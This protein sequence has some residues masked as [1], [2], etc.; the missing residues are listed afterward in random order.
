M[1]KLKLRN[2]VYNIPNNL[3]ELTIEQYQDIKNIKV[4]VDNKVKWFS[5]FLFLFGVDRKI[6]RMMNSI[7]IINTMNAVNVMLNNTDVPLFN[8]ITINN[9]KYQFENKLSNLRFDQFVDL[10]ELTD[11]ESIINDNIHVIAAILYRPIIGKVKEKFLI[12]NLIRFK[13]RKYVNVV[14]EYDSSKVID[15]SEIFKQHMNM[16]IIYGL[17]FFFSNLKLQ[18]SV[19][20]LQSLETEMKNEMKKEK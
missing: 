3:T 11:D 2:K 9:T 6:S 13:K 16:E 12:K 19:N 14:E 5:D 20:L 4:D 8:Y 15:R 17:L 1:I 10:S 18:H 7:D